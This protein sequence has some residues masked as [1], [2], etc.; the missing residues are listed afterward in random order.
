ME[1]L[2]AARDPEVVGNW[3][4][5]I[6]AT[7][8]VKPWPYGMP[9]SINPFVVFLGASPGGSPPAGDSTHVV[10]AP[11]PAPNASAH[12]KLGKEQDARHYWSRVCEL[13]SMIVQAHAPEVSDSQAHALIGQLNLGTEQHGNVGDAA[14]DPKYCSWVLEVILDYLRP[15]YVVMPGLRSRLTKRGAGF[16]PSRRLGIDWNKP[17]QCFSFQAYKRVQY[18][19]RLWNRKRSDGKA[20]RFILWPQHPSRAPMTDGRIWKE[21]AREFCEFIAQ[22]RVD[23]SL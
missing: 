13:G 6:S 1:R 8:P 23:T 10:C 20:V 14:F 18:K 12:P 19:F 22:D 3:P 9:S 5:R 7:A 21:S 2:A 17:D 4:D 11:Y 16:D 15:S